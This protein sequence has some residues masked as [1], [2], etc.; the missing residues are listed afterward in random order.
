MLRKQRWTSFAINTHSERGFFMLLILFVILTA[1]TS[2]VLNRLRGGWTGNL[3]FGAT[4]ARMIWAT[5]CT[6]LFLPAAWVLNMWS[7]WLMLLPVALWLGTVVGWQGSLDLGR[8]EG[9]RWRDFGVMTARGLL[10]TAPAAALLSWVFW[11]SPAWPLLVA[12]LACAV[13][14]ELA[15]HM[16]KTWKPPFAAGPEMGEVLFGAVVGTGLALS[17]ICAAF[18]A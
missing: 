2:A 5:G 1:V 8:N 13:C 11:P 3:P 14:Y 18:S 16:P 17:L 4:T 7:W 6:A 9:A 12:G 10:W 15:W